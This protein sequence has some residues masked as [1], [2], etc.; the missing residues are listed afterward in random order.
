MESPGYVKPAHQYGQPFP[1]WG[2]PQWE[3]AGEFFGS[4]VRACPACGGPAEPEEEDGLLKYVCT[5]CQYELGHTRL[6]QADDACSL[7][8]PEE[9]RR[10][11]SLPQA[12]PELPVFLGTIG[13]R[14]E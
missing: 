10:R 9:V 3:Q 5:G 13:R 14:P 12:E 2:V 7:G 1:D 8:V 4:P 6:T 11:S